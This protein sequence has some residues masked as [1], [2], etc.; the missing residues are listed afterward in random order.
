MNFDELRFF[1]FA[2]DGGGNDG[3]GDDGEGDDSPVN[4]DDWMADQDE[5][6]R[7]IIDN[8]TDALRGALDSERTQRKELAKQVKALSAKADK[9][10]E[11]RDSLDE[12]SG[13]L[14]SA[15]QRADFFEKVSGKVNNP[16]LAY[17]AA[18]D[19]GLFD[20]NGDVDIN[21]LREVAPEVFVTETKERQARG[22][23]GSGKGQDGGGQPDMNAFIR[24]SAGLT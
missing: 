14:E 24:R 22:N 17:L 15:N 11:L 7:S 13:K 18:Q 23:A 16:R 12:L 3:E 6:V 20:S 5:S 1:L 2:A 10:S 21:R 9:G 4:F 19:A 8:H